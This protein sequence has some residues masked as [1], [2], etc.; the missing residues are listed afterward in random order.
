MGRN[1]DTSPSNALIPAEM[2]P[3]SNSST[4][5]RLYHCDFSPI[6]NHMDCQLRSSQ[7]SYKENDQ[8]LSPFLL[9]RL[10][11]SKSAS[12]LDFSEHMSVDNSFNM[13]PEN[14]LPDRNNKTCLSGEIRWYILRCKYSGV[15]PLIYYCFI[16]T[17]LLLIVVEYDML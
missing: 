11:R 15:C 9:R 17:I 6:S 1:Y 16:F 7:R 5:R 14:D 4:P 3:I 2:S 13:A 8:T 12:R 10:R